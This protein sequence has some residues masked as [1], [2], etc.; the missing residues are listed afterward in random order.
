MPKFSTVFTAGTFLLAGTALGVAVA[1]WL[2]AW[3]NQ[4]IVAAKAAAPVLIGDVAGVKAAPGDLALDLTPFDAGGNTQLIWH[5]GKVLMGSRSD[6]SGAFTQLQGRVLLDPKARTLRAAEL[7][8]T[9]AAMRGH[10]DHP[11]PNA[12]INTVQEQGW[13]LDDQPTAVLRT[14]QVTPREAGAAAT[15]DRAVPD[16]THALTCTLRLNGI[17][18]ALT[19]YARLEVGE[20]SVRVDARF[21]ISRP[22]FQVQQRRGI[23]FPAEVDAE[24]LVEV[25]AAVS[26]DPLAVIAELNRQLVAQQAATGQL[27]SQVGTLSTR[28]DSLEAS[29]DGLR[30]DLRQAA[31]AAATPSTAANTPAGTS[32]GGDATA[33]PTASPTTTTPPAVDITALPPR[34]TDHVDY[35][36]PTK[37]AR[38]HDL[39]FAAPFEMVLVPGD[40]AQGVAPFYAQTTEVT[41][42]MFRTWSYCGDIAD[43]TLASSLKAALLRPSPC[44]DDASRGHG[45]DGRAVLG[46][47]RRNALA[48]CRF[49]SEQTGRS[50]RLWS[51]AEWRYIA[52]ATGGLPSNPLDVAWLADNADRDAFG[53]PLSMPV[54]KKPANSLGLYDFWGN[55]A[56]WVMGDKPYIRGGSYLVPASELQLEWRANESQAVWNLTYPNLPKSLW[57]YRDRFDMGFRLVCDPVGIPPTSQAK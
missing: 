54:G 24:V 16:W 31:S 38:L 45:F 6:Y 32:A 46:V 39:G 5:C 35:R 18:Q 14:Q 30:R 27:E 33:G 12:L 43:P 42:D 36:N 7:H 57:W 37:D 41:W 22:G 40:A 9:L 34:F 28:L 44:Y 8:V 55:V 20:A 25:H 51:E 19:V 52:N 48:F 21:P 56:E 29:I 10:G 49:V 2:Q 17:E 1:A 11:A 15:F 47:S 50:Y 23:S 4:P 53:E 3:S 26:P 13:F